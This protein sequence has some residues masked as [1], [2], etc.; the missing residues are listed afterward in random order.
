MGIRHESLNTSLKLVIL[1]FIFLQSSFSFHQHIFLFHNFIFAAFYICSA[2][3]FPLLFVTHRLSFLLFAFFSFSALFSKMYCTVN[4]IV[5]R[6]QYT[7]FHFIFPLFIFFLSSVI[8][9]FFPSLLFKLFFLLLTFQTSW[10]MAK[11]W[12]VV[13]L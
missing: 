5:I 7:R 6:L 3:S 9:L 12:L 1:F 13:S 10:N 4:L 2:L 11:N 8:F